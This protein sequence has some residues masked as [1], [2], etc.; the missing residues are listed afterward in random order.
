MY[1]YA[2]IIL[3][4]ISIKPV[5]TQTSNIKLSLEESFKLVQSKNKNL[6]IADI[7]IELAQ[8][9]HQITQSFWL[10]TIGATGTYMHMSN[11]IEVRENLKKYTD[12]VKDFMHDI[13]PTNL[14]IP[15]I[16]DQIGNKTL[17]AP[18]TPQ[19]ITTVDATITYP[20]FTGGKRIYAGK[21]GKELIKASKIGKLQVDAGLHITLIETYY[22]LRL[23][24]K[25]VEVR[26]QAFQS[27][28]QH[29]QN[30]L[31]LEENGMI[32]KAERLFSEVNMKEA[33]RM[34]ETAIKNQSLTE[35]GLKKLLNIDSDNPIEPISPLFINDSIPAS[36]YF[37]N[38]IKT[39]SYAIQQIEVLKKIND[40]QEKIAKSSYM[41]DIAL[42]GKQTLYSDGIS[43]NMVPRT[44]IGAGFIWNI[45]D[46]FAREKRIKETKINK[47]ILELQ[48]DKIIDDTELAID[49]FYNQIEN[50]LDNIEALNTTLEMSSELLRI[51]QK[52]YKEGMATSTEVVDAEVM[53]S[54]VQIAY[55]IAYY[56]YD[57]ALINILAICGI[58][59]SF[60][61]Y[62]IVGKTEHYIFKR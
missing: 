61:Q 40:S 14:L 28:E 33:K 48:N 9:E 41:P 35:S 62:K 52:A 25:I 31:K 39:N 23:S 24:Q 32:N 6:K 20:L 3:F 15:T 2:F 60:D 13:D 59:E 49:K 44:F 47:Q 17:V 55:L 38:L 58:P 30:A 46:G 18:L 42:L 21:I 10:P 12:P 4:I 19:N 50:A 45:F 54:N 36:S 51:R 11:K 16:L 5:S 34:L 57:L 56:E 22:G 8:N 7:Q 1:K 53:L 29:Y 37:K 26:Q 27:L 43:K